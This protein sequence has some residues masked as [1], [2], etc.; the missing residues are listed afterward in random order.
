MSRPN[1]VEI[2]SVL[3]EDQRWYA[4]LF[5]LLWLVG[6]SYHAVLGIWVHE[7]SVA[8]RIGEFSKDVGI[9][10]LSAA[11]LALMTIAGRRSAMALFDWPNKAKTREEG[12]Q[13]GRQE[14]DREWAEWNERREMAFREGREFTEPSPAEKRREKQTA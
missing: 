10:G 14:T 9:V 12:R 11:I 3:E 4:W 7:G 2:W 5:P 8:L 1:R 6:A 13:E